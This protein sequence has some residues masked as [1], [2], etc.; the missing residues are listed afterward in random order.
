MTIEEQTQ[1]LK[2]AIAE[3]N[4]ARHHYQND[5]RKEENEMKTEDEKKSSGVAKA[6]ADG[7]PSS[8]TWTSA[9]GTATVSWS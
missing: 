2:E 4:V 8:T 1:V 5:I 7:L 9:N 6:G 3:A